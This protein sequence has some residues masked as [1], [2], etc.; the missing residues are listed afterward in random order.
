VG[1]LYNHAVEQG[2][3]IKSF[4]CQETE[5]IFNGSQ[6]KKF[7]ADIQVRAERKLRMIDSSEKL[8][9]LRMPPG[10]HLESLFGD[11]KGQWSIKINDKYRICFEWRDG[12][13]KNVEIVDYH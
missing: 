10:N 6:S 1:I 12:E 3:M 13:A 7:P 4:R 5:I 11:R 9:D 2:R 8:D